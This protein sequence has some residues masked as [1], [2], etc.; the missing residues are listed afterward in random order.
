MRTVIGKSFSR[1]KILRPRKLWNPPRSYSGVKGIRVIAD[2]KLLAME[3][4][5]DKAIPSVPGKISG[6]ICDSI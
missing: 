5:W 6:E 3:L 4:V 1:I 2:S